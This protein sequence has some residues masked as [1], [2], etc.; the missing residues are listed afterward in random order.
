MWTCPKCG[1]NI[2]DQFVGCWKCAGAAQ[3]PKEGRV[4]WMSPA[5]SLVSLAVLFQVAPL[6]YHSSPHQHPGGYFS[7]G[8]ALLGVV[9]SCVCMRAFLRCPIRHWVAKILTLAFLMGVLWIG[10]VT[11]QSFLLHAF[12]YDFGWE[13][14]SIWPIESW[15][16]LGLL[17]I[18][19][20]SVWTVGEL[21]LGLG[22]ILAKTRLLKHRHA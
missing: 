7:L 9:A 19:A 8:G 3:A 14:A 10:V 11:A 16:Y 5:V 6:F 21:T 20:L 4:F 13:S 2:E 12:G 18:Y 1:E 22:R 15:P 17:C